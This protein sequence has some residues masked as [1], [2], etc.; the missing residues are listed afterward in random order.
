MDEAGPSE[1]LLEQSVRFLFSIKN[2][3]LFV[4]M[5]MSIL[6]FVFL[7]IN[8]MVCSVASISLR[9]SSVTVGEHHTWR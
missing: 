2:H 3:T 8:L 9:G 1:R 7:K 6:L 5:C 4:Q